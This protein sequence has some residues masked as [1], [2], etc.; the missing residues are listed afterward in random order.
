M[1]IADGFASGRG[2]QTAYAI[3]RWTVALV[4]EGLSFVQLRDHSVTAIKFERLVRK[5]VEELRSVRAGVVITLNSRMDLART[6][7]CGV[8]VGEHSDHVLRAACES[9][10][11]F[12]NS[13]LPVGYSAHTVNDLHEAATRDF[14][15]ATFSPIFPTASHPNV[16]ALGLEA[17][18]D[19][20]NAVPGLPIYALGGINAQRA[21][22]CIDAGAHG[23]AVVSDLLA[24][25]DPAG[26]LMGYRNVGLL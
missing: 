8:H 7:G 22:T 21:K 13:V 16:V 3:Q 14:T 2:W 4:E 11:V 10:E 20:C 15:F 12:E 6:L 5:L 26:V 25:S 19:A 18:A 17:L 1:L 23:V 24:A 9:G